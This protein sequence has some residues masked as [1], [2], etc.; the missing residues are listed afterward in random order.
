MNPE[1]QD[2]QMGPP[3]AS[4]RGARGRKRNPRVLFKV[5]HKNTPKLRPPGPY[6][7]RVPPALLQLQMQETP[8]PKK[9][10]RWPDGVNAGGKPIT[11]RELEILHHLCNG[12]SS[13]ESAAVLG[14]DHRTVEAHRDN[15]R[16]KAGVEYVGVQQIIEGDAF[17]VVF[18]PPQNVFW[19]TLYVPLAEFSIPAIERAI[20]RAQ[21][22]PQTERT[23]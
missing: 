6:P 3:V 11:Q 15:L 1:N 12:E 14:I 13:K 22:I 9:S 16:R 23:K 10:A 4:V 18:N 2:P 5:R 19:G 20:K 8:P 17:D 7:V 21:L